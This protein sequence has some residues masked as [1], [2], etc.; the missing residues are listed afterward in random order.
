MNDIQ[1]RCG[2]PYLKHLQLFQILRTHYSDQ[3]GYKLIVIRL[4]PGC[5]Y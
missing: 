4:P 3:A 1:Y 2:I 5:W